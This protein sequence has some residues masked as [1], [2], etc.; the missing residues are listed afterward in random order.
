MTKPLPWLSNYDARALKEGWLL[1]A[2]RIIERDDD[3]PRFK[4]DDAAYTYVTLRAMHGSRMHRAA[5]DQHTGDAAKWAN[6]KNAEPYA[7]ELVEALETLIENMETPR[8][9]KAMDA[10]QHAL[11]VLNK[12]RS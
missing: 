11:T 5:L 6:Q 10:W 12:A 3:N 1:S 8:S 7:G 2:D 4:D 9:R